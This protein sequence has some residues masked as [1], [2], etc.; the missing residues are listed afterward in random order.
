MIWEIEESRTVIEGLDEDGRPDPAYAAA[1]GL[2]PAPLGRRAAASIIEFGIFAFLQL[3]Y[4]IL[5]APTLLKVAT[6]AITP[7]GLLSHPN[8]VW[9]VVATAVSFVLSLAFVVVQLV[10][11]ARKGVTIGKAFMGI[12]SVNVKTL[13]KPGFGKAVLRALVMYLSFLVPVIGPVL[14]FVSPLL[15]G[16]KRGRGW[17]DKVGGTWFVDIRAGLDPY[18]EKRMRI[19]RKTVNA[20]PEAAK[21]ALPSLATPA[22]RAGLAYRP[23]ARTSSGVVGAARPQQPGQQQVGLASQPAAEPAP[24]HT[25]PGMP[26]GGARLGGYRPGELSGQVRSDAQ[27]TPSA[28]SAQPPASPISGIVD[29]V[30]GRAHGSVPQPAA[31]P[32]QQYQPPHAEA[33]AAPMSWAQPPAAA[34]AVQSSAPGAPAPA[35]PP[36]AHQQAMPVS[37][38]D[39]ETVIEPDFDSEI[40]DSTVRRVEVAAADDDDL[41]VTRARPGAR[42]A[43]ATLAFDTGDRFAISGAALVGRNPAPAAGEVV[44]HLLPISD[45]TRSISKTHLLITASPFA[46]VDRASTNGSSVVRAGVEHPLAPGAP[47]ALAVGDV[48]RFGDRAMTIEPGGTAW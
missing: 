35:Q 33:P 44:E 40:D 37:P 7:S 24:T 30:P 14:F 4:W 3:P 22:D 9:M 41:D 31:E 42:P 8:F 48:V 29:S 34:A 23:G 13:S 11:H 10:L 47:F 1:L 45:D 46:A 26:A 32:R 12:R 5:A 2:R 19:A 20:E 25:V 38:I 39:D 21:S 28:P 43:I 27:P 6:G 17:L 16:E 15:D 18:H 36:A